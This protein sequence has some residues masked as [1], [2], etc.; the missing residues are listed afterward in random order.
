MREHFNLDCDPEAMYGVTAEEAMDMLAHGQTDALYEKILTKYLAYCQ[1]KDFVLVSNSK[2]GSDGVNFAAQ[3]A[4]VRRSEERS[5]ELGNT[6]I[7]VV[8]CLR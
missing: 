7:T 8:I 3:M 6:T 1:D 4:Q 2:F 5:D